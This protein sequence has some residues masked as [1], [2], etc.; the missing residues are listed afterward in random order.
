MS[1]VENLQSVAKSA[2]HRWEPA[3]GT[4]RR[5]NLA[6]AIV[7][8][9]ED[10]GSLRYVSDS[11]DMGVRYCNNDQEEKIGDKQYDEGYQKQGI[12]K[13]DKQEDKQGDIKYGLEFGGT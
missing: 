3:V 8:Q 13:G 4:V 5:L 7:G 2:R 9:K 1:K 6:V 12:R 10:K 11:L